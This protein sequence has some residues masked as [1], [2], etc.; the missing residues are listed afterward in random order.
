MR[1]VYCV[2]DLHLGDGGPRD[3][4]AYGDRP[5]AFDAF[6]DHV[7][8]RNGELLILGDMFE[9]WQMNLSK[10]I[11]R[12]MPLLDRLARMDATFVAG[13][14][15]DDLL[16]FCGTDVLN[17][18]FLQTMTTRVVREIEGRTFE[19]I[20]GHQADPYCADDTPG[21]GRIT[22][23]YAGLREDK[24][25]S[26][27]KNDQKTVEEM[28]I[29]RMEKWLSRWYWLLGR[30]CRFTKMNRRLNEIRQCDMLI[31]GHTHRAGYH[32]SW[33]VNCGTWAERTPTYV[34]VS[35][36]GVVRLFEWNRAPAFYGG[37]SSYYLTRDE[38]R[39]PI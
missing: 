26:P 15:D 7:E 1:T 22:S 23:I 34:T 10:I 8:K 21:L 24:N 36:D 29:G 39:L 11:M 12:H 31:C 18:P 16:H 35:G 38:N 37:Y 30:P 2:S 3:N 17:H 4:F 28:T 25:G 19:F 27:W 9:F 13:N 32:G 6:L 5:E 20:H 14:H 33:H